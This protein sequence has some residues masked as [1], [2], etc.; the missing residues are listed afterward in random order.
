[1]SA[2]ACLITLPLLLVFMLLGIV[3]LILA[4]VTQARIARKL[5]SFP[6][7]YK[8][9]LVGGKSYLY[10]EGLLS[11]GMPQAIQEQ[12]KLLRY[13][14][15]GDYVGRFSDRE[16]NLYLR[17]WYGAYIVVGLCFVVGV[18]GAICINGLL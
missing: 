6:D 2:P 7:D 14:R 18:G 3:L 5:K 17:L 13:F 8:R 15:D 11:Q 9:M 10:I 16:R 12:M 1:M 4:G